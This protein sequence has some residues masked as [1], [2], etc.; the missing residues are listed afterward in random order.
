MVLE[1]RRPLDRPL[2]DSSGAMPIGHARAPSL[3]K[4]P[5][6]AW[7]DHSFRL[8]LGGLPEPWA[9]DLRYDQARSLAPAR[10]MMPA[11]ARAQ[12]DKP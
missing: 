1:R 12:E 7:L 4:R 3:A 8:G 6:Q 5:G 2:Q 10:L 9:P 11:E